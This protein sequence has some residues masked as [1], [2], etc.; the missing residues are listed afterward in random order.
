MTKLPDITQCGLPGINRIPFGMHV[1]HFYR[2]RDELIAA[3]APYFI[4]GLRG[5]ERCLWIT[6]PPLPASEAV[7]VLRAAWDGVDNAIHAGA[8][9]IID[10]DRWYVS[11][12]RLKG[13]EV[14]QVWLEEEERALADGYTGLRITRN[15]G[16]LEPADWPSF[17]EYEQTLSG[18]FENRRILTLCSYALAGCTDQQM[19]DVMRAH[20]FR[21]EHRDADWQ[22][23]SALAIGEEQQ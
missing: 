11:A 3:L 13:S 5:N 21:L 23:S 7:Q 20:H 16:F 1:C 2:D 8:L 6:A 17:T 9:R 10:F 12:G 14:A 22:V 19:S 4:A 18:L 15:T